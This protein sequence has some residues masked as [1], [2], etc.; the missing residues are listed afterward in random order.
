VF[1]FPSFLYRCFFLSPLLPIAC[2][3][4]RPEGCQAETAPPSALH[5]Q[6]PGATELAS[7]SL[8]R[9]PASNSPC[10]VASLNKKSTATENLDRPG[11]ANF[12]SRE[13]IS[14]AGAASQR[15]GDLVESVLPTEQDSTDKLT[16]TAQR[17]HIVDFSCDTS[18]LLAANASQHDSEGHDLHLD[19]KPL[20]ISSSLSTLPSASASARPVPCLAGDTG[21]EGHEMLSVNKISSQRRGSAPAE[22]IVN[23]KKSF[24]LGKLKFGGSTLEVNS[25]DSPSDERRS[26]HLESNSTPRDSEDHTS[27]SF[28]NISPSRSRYSSSMSR[29]PTSQEGPKASTFSLFTKLN[30]SRDQ[31]NVMTVDAEED[32]GPLTS[33]SLK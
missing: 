1:R 25:F 19:R 15:D 27:P 21:R 6:N 17:D 24:R 22:N 31:L 18:A 13:R 8:A 10:N 12:P 33:S 20:S 7:E 32:F 3:P 9:T 23:T 4:D 2:S 14:L 28:G 26:S 11:A 5:F 29:R 30:K 16:A